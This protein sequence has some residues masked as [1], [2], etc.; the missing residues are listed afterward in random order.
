MKTYVSVNLEDYWMGRDSRYRGEWTQE[1]R[2]NAATLLH[3]VNALL[4]HMDEG[5]V[6][7]KHP[8]GT[9]VSSGWRPAA[10]NASVPGAAVKSKHMTAQAIDLY[11]PD[12]E[13]DDWCMDHLDKLEQCGIWIEHPSATKGWSHMQSVPPRSGK[14]VFYP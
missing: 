1:I 9:L 12:G 7:D 14:R 3:R 13:I 8:N 5:V 2:A 11:D 6:F 10:V 4:A